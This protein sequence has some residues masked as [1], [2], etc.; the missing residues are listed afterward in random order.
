MTLLGLPAPR[1]L[2]ARLRGNDVNYKL[3]T[4]NKRRII[5]FY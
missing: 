1:L 3:E 4:I 5:I 2:E